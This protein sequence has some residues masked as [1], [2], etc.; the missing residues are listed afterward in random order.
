MISDKFR[1]YTS[2]ITYLLPLVFSL[3][4]QKLSSLIHNHTYKLLPP[5]S[6]KTVL[7]LGGS[8]AG[9]Q[10][11]KRLCH[12]LPTGYRVMLVEKNSHLNYL[13]TFPRFSVV[14]G[15][16]QWAFIP[17]EGVAKGAPRGIFEFK[18]GEAEQVLEGEVLLKGGERVSYAYLVVATGT[19]SALPSKVASTEREGA[20]KELV[21]MQD[22]IGA[23]QR[24][25]V[26]GGGAVGVELASDIK[27]FYPEKDVA[28]I[29]SRE[30]L[31]PSFGR[32]LHE[33]TM[34]IFEELGIAVLLNER[35]I[36]PQG[37]GVLKLLNGK[38]ESFDLI[39]PCTGQRPNSSLIATL[40][41]SSIS[42]TTSRILVLPTLQISD[43]AYPNI[44]S[45]GDVAETGGPK[46][47]RA[48]FFQS[49]IVVSN[50]LALIKGKNRELKQYKPD[51]AM[52][53]SIK[54][55]LGKSRYVMYVKQN[56]GRELIVPMEN[57][58]VDLGV[59]YQWN[60]FGADKKELEQESGKGGEVA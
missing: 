39:I 32:R 37:G 21:S 6:C 7:I 2:F 51:L 47:A 18:Q 34:K 44:F 42:K 13:F 16:E 19:L 40:S 29:H 5:E 24:I 8:F 49:E 28:I 10:L 26:V 30:Q 17:Y 20:M 59:K 56:S 25:A 60:F 35:P 1:L 14:R 11:A 15:H 52:E 23:A 54:L 46:M 3:L 4:R 9:F 31:L 45:F 27:D 33:H 38:E 41:P 53:G 58:P 55:T 36:L 22:R 50:L 57:N 43:P 12:T 48:G